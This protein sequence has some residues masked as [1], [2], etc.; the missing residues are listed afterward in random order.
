[1]CLTPRE[2]YPDFDEEV[3]DLGLSITQ[4]DTLEMESVGGQHPFA[5]LKLDQGY[6][7][8]NLFWYE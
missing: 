5:N 3:D 2:D 6:V 1:M 8:T 7:A 4:Y